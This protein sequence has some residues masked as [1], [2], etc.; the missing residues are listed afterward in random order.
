MAPTQR[1]DLLLQAH[2]AQT[3]SDCNPVDPAQSLQLLGKIGYQANPGQ[4]M[5]FIAQTFFQ[6]ERVIEKRTGRIINPAWA[7]ALTAA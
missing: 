2:D 3:M 5:F 4:R 6:A 1:I 7:P